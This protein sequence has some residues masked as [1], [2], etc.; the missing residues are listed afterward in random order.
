[1]KQQTF[2]SA[3]SADTRI[4]ALYETHADDLWAAVDFHQPSE[5]VMPP[6]ESSERIGTGIG[7]IKINTLAGGGEVQLQ[8]VY[9]DSRSRAFNYTIQQSP[10][11]VKN[12]V[13]QVRVTEAEDGRAQLT[14]QGC[15]EP[16]GVSAEEAEQI[17]AGF[18]GSIAEKLGEMFKRIQ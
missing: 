9:Y 13:G 16:A 2:D 4:T 7:A 6:I 14:W 11:P 18:Y 10:L 1:M 17:L 15:Y 5:N 12:Y 3:A 8:L